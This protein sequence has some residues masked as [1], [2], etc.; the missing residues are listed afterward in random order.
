MKRIGETIRRAF[1]E[2]L[3]VPSLIIVGFLLLAAGTTALDNAGGGLLAPLGTAMRL[4]FFRDG[5]ATSDLLAT[6]AGSIITVTSITFS[7]LLLAVQQAA[8]SL[9]HQVYDQFLRRRVNQSYFGFFVGLA[10]Y[11]LIILASVNT[12]F[13][14]VF[15]ASLALLLTVIALTLM[16]LLLYTTINQM[17]P[18]VVIATIHDHILVARRNQLAFLRRTRRSS[19]TDGAI[20]GVVRAENHG[21]IVRVDSEALGVHLARAHQDVEVVLTVSI[22]A[23]IAFHDKLAE[24]RAPASMNTAELEKAVAGAIHIEQQR[25]LDTDP[26]YG[27]EQLAI[28]GWTSVSTAK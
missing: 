17:R 25:D 28:I 3:G 11:T 26:A 16:I 6:I 13:N 24:I 14:P 23:F 2:F 12:P 5:K 19:R 18:G 9:T 15:G 7:L 1:A 21:Y 27:I 8:G 4:H 20:V 22:G 10:L